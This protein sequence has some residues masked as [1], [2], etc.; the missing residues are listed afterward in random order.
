MVATGAREPV[1]TEPLFVWNS[2]V[3]TCSLIVDRIFLISELLLSTGI[4]LVSEEQSLQIV[5]V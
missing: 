3:G 4:G 5:V 2:P 1:D